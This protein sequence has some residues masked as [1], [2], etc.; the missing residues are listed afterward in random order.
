MRF[1]YYRD[2][3]VALEAFKANAFDFRRENT[4]KIW[5]TQYKFP[6]IKDGRVIKKT[7]A[8]GNPTGMQSFAFNLRR[9][10]FQDRRVRQALALTF[11]FEWANKNLFFD[12]Y[13][14]TQSFFSN[15][16][17][18]SHG[19]PGAA[20]L[21]LLEPLRGQIPED[22]F[23]KAYEAPKTDGSGKFRQHLRQAKQLLNSASWSVKEG[24]LTN[25]TTGQ[26]MEIEILL[27][28][29][30]FERIVA[31]MQ[32]AMQRLGVKVSLR[33]VD[34]SQYINRLRDFD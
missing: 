19:L 22:V 17:L 3:T 8:N 2:S 32:Q 25:A 20:E 14:R 34:T 26:A 13:T 21:K 18:A 16:E 30:G 24:R 28:N 31:P 6:T 15:S 27:V 7:L 11:D 1:E 9:S 23:T 10:K 4:S 5:A 12:Q 29:Q 33:L